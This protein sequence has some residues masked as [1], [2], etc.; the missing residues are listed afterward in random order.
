MCE[1]EVQ[2]RSTGRTASALF[3]PDSYFKKLLGDLPVPRALISTD[4]LASPNGSDPGNLSALPGTS[5]NSGHP[6]LL[7]R[8]HGLPV[9]F[10]THWQDR[11][12]LKGE[13]RK[14]AG[15]E[16][17]GVIC[18]ILGRGREFIQEYTRGRI[19]LNI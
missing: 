8:D 13:V 1:L 6:W 19:K 5:C 14:V 7:T 15:V 3:N 18:F 17:G 9:S 2:S 16:W 12:D 4:Q 11:D 10:G